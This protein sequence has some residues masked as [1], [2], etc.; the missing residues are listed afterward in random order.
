MPRATLNPMHDSEALGFER[1]RGY[2]RILAQCQLS[3]LYRAKLDASDVAQEVLLKAWRDRAQFHGASDDDISTWLKSILAHTLANIFRDLRRDKRDV[4]LE[5]SLE[6][7][8]DRSSV[9]ILDG[10]AA[11]GTS[12]SGCA[13]RLEKLGRVADAL[14]LLPES[15]RQAVVL[16]H[17]GG[18]SLEEIATE[19]DKSAGAVGLLIHRGLSRLRVELRAE[20]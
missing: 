2:L 20:L 10:L 11:D 1:F 6:V 8:L 12:P 16:R 19:V 17:W 4:R 13:Q 9:A 5:Q 7:S 15:Q 3:G 18:L 14:Q